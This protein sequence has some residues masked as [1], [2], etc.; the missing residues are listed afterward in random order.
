MS[1][2]T[3]IRA[4][5]EMDFGDRA[6]LLP[7]GLRFMITHA[8]PNTQELVVTEVF[9]AA[10]RPSLP[11]PPTLMERADRYALFLVSSGHRARKDKKPLPAHGE[12][13]KDD[14]FGRSAVD[15]VVGNVLGRLAD[16]RPW[17]ELLKKASGRDGQSSFTWA[18]ATQSPLVLQV[19]TCESNPQNVA[20]FSF[21]RRNGK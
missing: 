2:A 20:V 18:P 12:V 5:V 4:S 7:P 17:L 16:E 1:V 10:K 6:I 14:H 9:D 19:C 8:L 11:L 21:F 3:V 15:Q 13:F